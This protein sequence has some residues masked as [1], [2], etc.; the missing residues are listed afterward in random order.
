MISSAV[1]QAFTGSSDTATLAFFEAGWVDFLQKWIPRW[2]GTS[3]T[4]TEVL[5]GPRRMNGTLSGGRPDDRLHILWLAEAIEASSLV[6]V[7]YR[8]TRDSSWI[9]LST[10]ANGAADLTDF[11][12]HPYA[13]W[14]DVGMSLGRLSGTFPEGKKNIQVKYTHGY[15]ED[16]GPADVTQVLLQLVK[17][18]L[19]GKAAGGV[20]QREKG[21]A[22]ITYDMA[23]VAALPGVDM[24]A[25]E[26]LQRRSY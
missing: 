13:A 11:E 22:S 6:S 19:A 18:S 3:K 26:R 2:L 9:D 8:S 25:L 24:G 4:L 15:V 20:K 14:V 1:L 16:A 17:S 23:A 12:I 21:T 5:D 10:D 7:K